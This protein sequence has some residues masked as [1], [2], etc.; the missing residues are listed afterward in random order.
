MQFGG[1]YSKS[2][3]AVEYAKKATEIDSN[4]A[5][6]FKALGLAYLAQGKYPLALEANQQASIIDPKW[7]APIN[8]S[9]E[10]QSELGNQ[11]AAYQLIQQ[12]IAL[13]VKDPIPYA[14]LGVIYQALSLNEKAQEAYQYCLSLKPDYLFAQ[15]HMVNFWISINNYSSAQSMLDSIFSSYPNNKD[16]LYLQGLLPPD[17]E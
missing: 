12:A 5:G 14:Q 6:A 13:D 17:S 2:Q 8:N 11:V 7:A 10:L 4:N 16:A 9:A 1:S 3:L 15:L